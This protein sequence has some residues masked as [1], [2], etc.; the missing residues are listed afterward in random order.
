MIEAIE[1]QLSLTPELVEPSKAS[2]WRY[3]NVSSSSLWYT[4]AYIE[5]FKVRGCPAM[6]LVLARKQMHK[7]TCARENGG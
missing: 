7:D 1:E 2:L 3:G 6:Q 5:T 4:L